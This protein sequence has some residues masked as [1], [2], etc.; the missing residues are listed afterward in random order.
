MADQ[1]DN[2]GKKGYCFMYVILFFLAVI[3][4]WAYVYWSNFKLTF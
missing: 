4:T 3:I 1:I 2:S